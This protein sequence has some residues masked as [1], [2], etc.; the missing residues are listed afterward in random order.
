M[1]SKGYKHSDE[2][3]KKI[4]EAAKGRRTMLDK[5]HTEETKIKMS[6]SHKGDK[7]YMFGKNHSI[8]TIEKLREIGRSR[9]HSEETKLKIGQIN[10]DAHGLYNSLNIPKYDLYAKQIEYAEKVRRNED[11]PNILEVTCFRFVPVDERSSSEETTDRCKREWFVPTIDAVKNRINALEGRYGIKGEHHLYCSDEC[12]HKC[13]IF[14][15]VWH[16]GAQKKPDRSREV[17]AQLAAMVLERDGY[18]CIKCGSKEKLECHHIEGIHH[19]PME[20]ADMD[21]CVT[22]CE[23]CHD[24]AHKEKGC[25]YDDMKCKIEDREIFEPPIDKPI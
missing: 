22:F 17:Q 21:V 8:E 24:A 4:G 20:S 23:I 11:D 9:R 12:K 25:T 7:N 10:R 19:E 3:K 6:E 2:A 13:P 5:H 18:A 15:K 16:S 1:G 14:G